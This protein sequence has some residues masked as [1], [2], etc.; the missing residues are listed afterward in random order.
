MKKIK[1]GVAIIVFFLLLSGCTSNSEKLKILEM[2]LERLEKE[3]EELRLQGSEESITVDLEGSKDEKSPVGARSN[4]VP[5]GEELTFTPLYADQEVEITAKVTDVK[6]GTDAETEVS[7]YEKIHVDTA[8]GNTGG[9]KENTEFLTYTIIIKLVGVNRDEGI[10]L[11][12]HS[13]SLT[14]DGDDLGYS[15]AIDN[16]DGFSNEGS[17][18]VDKEYTFRMYGQIEKGKEGLISLTDLNSKVFFKVN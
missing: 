14:I 7:Q 10:R 16:I 17:V 8:K 4:P 1:L 15:Y 18:Y 3:N 2:K 9:L 12:S 13:N 5:V 11:P 6:R